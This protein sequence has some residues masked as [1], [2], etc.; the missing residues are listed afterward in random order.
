M[1]QLVQAMHSNAGADAA[2]DR[3]RADPAPDDARQDAG[4]FDRDQGRGVAQPQVPAK[5]VPVE[6]REDKDKKGKHDK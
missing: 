6:H 2:G 1:A 4:E 5:V 3:A